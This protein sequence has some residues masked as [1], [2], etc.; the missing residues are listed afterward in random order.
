M[1]KNEPDPTSTSNNKS[2]KIVSAVVFVVLVQTGVILYLLWGFKQSRNSPTLEN[3][4]NAE[5]THSDISHIESIPPYEVT[6]FT[7]S[8]PVKIPPP[9]KGSIKTTLPLRLFATMIH[10]TEE[11]KSSATIFYESDSAPSGNLA[12]TFILGQLLWPKSNIFGSTRLTKIQ[13]RRVYFKHNGDLEYLDM[14][15]A[16]EKTT[17]REAIQAKTDRQIDNTINRHHDSDF[18]QTSD[19]SWVINRK[20][21]SGIIN[22]PGPV[23][24]SA[25]AVPQLEN[26]H[27][28]G[29][30]FESIKRDSPLRDMG[31]KAGDVLRQVNGHKIDS[32]DG[33]L[34]LV[35]QLKST[36][37]INLGLERDGEATS[38]DYNIK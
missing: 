16:K 8:T 32:I 28:V 35:E 3:N 2:R 36:S 21:L 12:K 18:V 4:N 37:H 9:D 34:K 29:F 38:F 27:I 1:P 15:L 22:D 10:P 33:A 14:F 7:D 6:Q 25:R 5:T 13:K 26:G 24:Q 23:L 19:T 17:T 20:Q 30:R 11:K 31:L